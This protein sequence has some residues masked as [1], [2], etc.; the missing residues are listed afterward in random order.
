MVTDSVLYQEYVPE[1]IELYYPVRRMY[2]NINLCFQPRSMKHYNIF[3]YKILKG[4]KT[5]W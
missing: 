4:L 5:V 1:R 3:E 2:L